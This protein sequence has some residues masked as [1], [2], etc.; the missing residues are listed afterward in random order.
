MNTPFSIENKKILITGASSGIGKAIAIESSKM[1]AQLVLV[2]RNEKRLLETYGC[3]AGNDHKTIVCDLTLSEDI[4]NLLQE[5]VKLD[6]VVCN[7]GA[8]MTKPISFVNSNDLLNILSINTF[9][10]ILLIKELIKQKKISKEG[11]V[12]FTSSI[13]S[14]RA[15][16]G[17]SIYGVSKAGLTAFMR[18]LALELSS[19]R[20]RCNAV[21][22]GMVET[23]LIEDPTYSSDDIAKD[24]QNYPLGRYGKPEEIAYAVIYFLSDASKWVTG[25]S[26]IIDGGVMLK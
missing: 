21:L 6:G 14:L 5:I 2:G 23:A 16:L 15:D 4:H 9:A 13:A 1:G 11:S 24:K 17:N 20:I 8:S 7:A 3:L 10:P 18:Y 25:S 12:V 22:P 19:K 26:L